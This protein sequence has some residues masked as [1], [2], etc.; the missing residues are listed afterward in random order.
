[1]EKR[2][3][4]PL[5]MEIGQA[6]AW[7]ISKREKAQNRAKTNLDTF[8]TVFHIKLPFCSPP[9]GL[10][11]YSHGSVQSALSPGPWASCLNPDVSEGC[12]KCSFSAGS[13]NTSTWTMFSKFQ[14]MLSHFGLP[15]L[16]LFP[17]EQLSSPKSMDLP[18]LI[19][20]QVQM[21]RSVLSPKHSQWLTVHKILPLLVNLQFGRLPRLK[22]IF[23]H[24]LKWLFSPSITVV[25]FAI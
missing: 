19:D 10:A 22:Q 17:L 3:P 5:H 21:Q 9:P 23:C 8:F 24:T 12:T 25:L 6:G 4:A 14:T 18:A 2:S 20:E 11:R 16:Q 7:S 13:L 15:P 1:M